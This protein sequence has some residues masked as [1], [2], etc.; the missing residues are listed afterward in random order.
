MPTIELNET[1]YFTSQFEI[2]NFLQNNVTKNDKLVK[3]FNEF[4]SSEYNKTAYCGVSEI[5]LCM[6]FI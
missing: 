2:M 6:C 5:L 1:Q 4:F 3:R